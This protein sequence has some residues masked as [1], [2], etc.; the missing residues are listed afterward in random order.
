MCKLPTCTYLGTYLRQTGDRGLDDE[1]E[2]E[3]EEEEEGKMN[4]QGNN[5]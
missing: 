3:E 5:R 2:E 1:G 4:I